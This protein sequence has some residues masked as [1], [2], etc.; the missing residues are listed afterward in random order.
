MRNVTVKMSVIPFLEPIE[1]RFV[2]K[3]AEPWL[4]EEY[5][6]ISIY[7]C[8][9]YLILVFLGERWMRDKP[10]FSLRRPLTMW[11]TGLAVFST[12][13]F[14][15]EI[16]PL[17]RDAL[18][19]GFRHSVCNDWVHHNPENAHVALWSLLF[20]LSKTVELGDTA[21]VVLRK[22]PLNFLHWYHHVT[23]LVYGAYFS[24]PSPALSNWFT[25]ANCFVHSIMYSY[26]M[27]KSAGF[28]VPQAV[29]QV[30][31]SLQLAQFV[32]GLVGILTAYIQKSSGV[33]CDPSYSF[34]NAGLAIY[35]SYFVLFLNF[36]YQRYLR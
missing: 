14:L 4:S 7:L 8:T 25:T 30:I 32:L 27:L 34:L 24:G 6:K 26:Y 33:E 9:V 2:W 15:T 13:G 10:A 18:D 29:A 36:F 17:A 11:N 3:K 23:V 28:K 35:G 16:I 1:S 5:G 12:V 22:T 19:N 20:L 31:T 21:F